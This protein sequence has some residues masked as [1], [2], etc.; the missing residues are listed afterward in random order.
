[1]GEPIEMGCPLA[2]WPCLTHPQSVN[3]SPIFC[4]HKQSCLSIP[5]LICR[6]KRYPTV[7]CGMVDFIDQDSRSN[8]G[9]MLQFGVYVPVPGQPCASAHSAA[10]YA[11]DATF[12]A[13]SWVAME[14]RLPRL[15]PRWGQPPE[16][17]LLLQVLPSPCLLWTTR[18]AAQTRPWPQQQEGQ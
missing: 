5:H 14:E 6:P 1:V 3:F 10:Q 16:Q 8:S 4:R 9:H 2:N 12:F 13:S 17:E 7:D 18:S 11:P 15:L